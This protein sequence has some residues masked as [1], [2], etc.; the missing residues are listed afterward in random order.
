MSETT[1]NSEITESKYKRRRLDQKPDEFER[2][3][4]E[5]LLSENPKMKGFG[6]QQKFEPPKPPE[7]PK[8]VPE[9]VVEW[10]DSEKDTTEDQGQSSLTP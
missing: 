6:I 8:D 2:E 4:N 1:E 7:K 10:L 3:N 5:R 9:K